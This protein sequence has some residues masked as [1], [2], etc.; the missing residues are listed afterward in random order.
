[1]FQPHYPETIKYVDIDNT[2]ISI[3]IQELFAHFS[4][5][6]INTHREIEQGKLDSF[7]KR[8]FVWR[9]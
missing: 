7:R 3:F 4:W 8:S 9:T 1:M 2:L 5:P 6:R